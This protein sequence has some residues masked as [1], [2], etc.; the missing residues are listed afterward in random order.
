M[1]R[2]AASPDRFQRI[3]TAQPGRQ[4]HLGQGL[5]PGRQGRGRPGA[6]LDGILVDI[7][8]RKRIEEALLRSEQDYRRLFEHAHDA[9]V[10]F[11]V[12]GEIIL[13]VNNRACELYGFSRQEM[14]GMSLEKISK[15]VARGKRASAD[16]GKGF[17]QFRDRP[18]PQ[19]RQRDAAG[20]QCGAGHL[21]N[22]PAILSI[23]RDITRRRLL[24]ETIRQMA[25]QDSLTGLPNRS[26]L[27]DRLVQAL[28]L[29]SAA[30]RK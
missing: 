17:P 24:E 2:L 30:P 9:I 4:D 27:N 13:D 21:Q 28:A 29:P 8:E 20:G 16:A 11:A 7:S 25:Y 26:L 5:P 1:Q 3:R 23:N 22:Q 12:K 15:D 6:L 14:I 18:F 10:I 19:G